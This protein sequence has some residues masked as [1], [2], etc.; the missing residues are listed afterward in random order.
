M[1]LQYGFL[2]PQGNPLG[3]LPAAY[4]QRETLLG[5]YRAMVLTRQFD[6]KA[7][8][9]QR[10]GRLGTYASSLG[11][12]AV[13]VGVALAMLDEDVLVPSFREHGTQLLRGVSMEEILLFWGG[14]E[15]GSDFQQARGDFP[16][17][18]TVGGHAP[19]AVGVALALK[20]KQAPAA[21]VCMFGDGATSKGDVYEAMNIASAW[22]VPVLFVV[23]NNQWAISTAL[24]QQTRSE[25]LADKAMAVGMQ[26]IQVDGNDVCAVHHAC[27]ALLTGMR[28]EPRPALL[29][30]VT[31]RL[32]D[33]TTAD[34]AS[35]YRSEQLVREM[36]QAE[37]VARLRKHLM[38]SQGLSNAEEEALQQECR[39]RVAEGEAAYLQSTPQQPS[40]MFD[41]M[42]ATLPD[43]LR[44]QREEFLEWT[45]QAQANHG[46]ADNA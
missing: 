39:E 44:R 43:D 2:D 1:E 26:G 6:A 17:C 14:D 38:Q 37:P 13:S 7:V 21:A 36:W 10:T 45:N 22:Q 24:E 32:A 28:E 16:V 19:H 9:L 20:M 42:Y 15:R 23:S 29:E 41:Y 33:H 46:G 8:A 34:D 25:T 12:E 40:A 30:A 4:L 31:F 27:E 11:Q 5:F 18:I 35:R 3:D